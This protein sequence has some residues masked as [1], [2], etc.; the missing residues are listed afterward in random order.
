MVEM[1]RDQSHTGNAGVPH[2]VEVCAVT[3]ECH[4]DGVTSNIKGLVVE[5]LM[6]IANE[7]DGSIS[8]KFGE[9]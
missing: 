9:S 3:S 1:D 5:W 7:L 8:I 2:C 4:I 6:N